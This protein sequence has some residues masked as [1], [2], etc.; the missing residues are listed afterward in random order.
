MAKSI[1][2]MRLSELLAECDK[3]WDYDIEVAFTYNYDLAKFPAGWQFNVTNDWYK[4]SDAKFKHNFGIYRTPEYAII[5]F[6]EY[7]KENKIKVKK[8]ANRTSLKEYNRLMKG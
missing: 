7:V 4:W 2:D 3:L 1:Y 5:A 6:L 8:L